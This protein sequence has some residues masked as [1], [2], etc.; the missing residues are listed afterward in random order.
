MRLPYAGQLLCVPYKA[1]PP[2]WFF[3]QGQLLSIAD[4]QLLYGVI[5]TTFGGDG[6]TVFALPDLRGRIPIGTGQGPGLPGYTLGDTAGVEVVWLSTAQTP[7]HIHQ[8]NAST[9]P[10]NRGVPGAAVISPNDQQS[11]SF[12]GSSDGSTMNAAMIE[13]TPA[14]AEGHENRQP[15][16]VLNWIIAAEGV[17]PSPGQASTQ[18]GVTNH[19]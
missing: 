18:Q 3:C 4:Y 6:E 19:E 11:A 1:C 10:G 14:P 2:G 16:L 13:P 8:V 9:V 12:V 7:P 5:G 15:F 17:Y